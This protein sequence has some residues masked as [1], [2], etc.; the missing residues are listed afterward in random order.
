VAVSSGDLEPK[1][2]KM[3]PGGAGPT[4]I[5]QGGADPVRISRISAA[6]R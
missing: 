1:M 2:T 4:S 6:V 5:E 3:G